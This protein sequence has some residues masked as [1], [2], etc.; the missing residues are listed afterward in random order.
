MSIALLTTIGYES[1]TLAPLLCV[2][3]H[4]G[5]RRQLCPRLS[6]SG[7]SVS[8]W[9][10]YIATI[11]VGVSLDIGNRYLGEAGVTFTTCGKYYR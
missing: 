11:R 3:A 7:F 6:E 8:G 10:R 1:N 9:W 4:S 2:A 5:S